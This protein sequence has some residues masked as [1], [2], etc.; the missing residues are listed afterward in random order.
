MIKAEIQDEFTS[1]FFDLKTT[2]KFLKTSLSTYKRHEKAG[3]A[4]AGKQ[5]FGRK[6]VYLKSD[7]FLFAEGKW[8]N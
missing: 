7:I 5:L 4:P 6:K 2:C 8:K 1:Y 3:L